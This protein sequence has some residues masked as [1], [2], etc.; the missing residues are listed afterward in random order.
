MRHPIG[1]AQQLW[2][3][4]GSGRGSLIVRT[5]YYLAIIVGLALTHLDPD[6]LAIPF[7]YQA[8]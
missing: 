8:F 4:W 6:R 7:I 1:G 2:R 3:V 5:L